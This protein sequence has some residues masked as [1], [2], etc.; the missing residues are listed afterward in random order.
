MKKPKF[1]KIEPGI[2]EQFITL[3]GANHALTSA[4]D[5]APHVHEWR[6]R[7]GGETQLVLKPENTKEVSQIVA[8]ANETRTAIVPQGGN[9]GLVGGQIP[10]SS[11]HEIVLNL[12]RLN[13]I[14]Q[15]DP[16]NN[17]ITVEAGCILENI[18]NV[19]KENDRLFP[20]SLA[21]EGSCQ[22]GGNLSSNAG[23]TNVIKYGSARDLALGLEVVLADGQILNGLNALRKNNTGYDLRNIFIGAEGTL[24]IITAAVM[25]LYNQPRDRSTAFIA[26]KTPR[27]AVELLHLAQEYSGGLVNGFELMPLIGLSFVLKHATS[28]RDPLGEP[29][30]WYVL[31]E[32]SGGTEPGALTATSEKILSL[33]FEKELITDAALASNTAQADDFWHLRLAL[34]EVQKSEGASIKQ[35]V[36]VPISNIA[37]FLEKADIAVKRAAPNC[38]PVPFGHIGDG[39]IHYN[40]SQ[41]EDMSKEDFFAQEDAISSLIYDLVLSLG[42]SISAEHGIGK[43]KAHVMKDIKSP[44]E[45]SLMRLLK[46]TFDPKNILNPGKTLPLEE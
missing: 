1:N 43:I 36:S 23:G 40:I 46:S 8:L 6:G 26:L 44:A 12:S 37:T 31:M 13:K 21:S 16:L 3:V 20:L 18:Q 41:P 45:L 15:V 33:A 5:I 22:I 11:E 4:D 38:R 32:I 27:H 28:V 9:T 7:Y 25:K 24:G 30:P 39:N 35:D 19:A 2:I 14:R 34:S 42:G 29:S 10:Y 17:T